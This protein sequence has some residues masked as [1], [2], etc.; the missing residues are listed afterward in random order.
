MTNPIP[1]CREAGAG[2]GSCSG[3]V[4]LH[5]NASSSSQWRELLDALAPTHHGLAPDSYNAGKSP[6][7]LGAGRITL[8][9]EVA[10]LES[11]F[12]RAGDPFTLVGHSY[13]GAIALVA[14]A[15]QP[16]RLRALV[17]YEPTLFALL[18]AEAP[19]PNHGDGI[20]HAV[21]AAGAALDAGDADAAA[22]HFIDYWMAAGTWAGTPEARKPSITA[23]VAH[24]RAWGATLFG[25]PTPLAAF[26]R[27]DLPVLLMVGS[28]S[29]AS[30]R[31]V[32]RLLGAALP[33]VK[34]LEFPG[35]GHMGPI[36]HAPRVNA[37]IAGFLAD[38][39]ASRP[40]RTA[41][42]PPPC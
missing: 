37:A 6:A 38:L 18:D 8:R 26:A 30:S 27:L 33:N 1:F 15:A 34:L 32:A 11:V 36:T 22:R 12:A 3:V 31:G 7:W 10:L 5:S 14:A 25:E 19:P 17:L 16:R 4:C 9:D 35:L 23:A 21:D 13:G 2:P 29:P 42:A 20:R 39:S 24:V 40:D 28:E 41:S